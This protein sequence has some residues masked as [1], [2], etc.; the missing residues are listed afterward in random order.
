VGDNDDRGAGRVQLPQ[1]R[2]DLGAGGRVE[3][4][5][6]LVGQHQGR[7][8]GHG[9]G[10]GDPLPLATGQLV[11]PVVEPVPKPDPVE[12]GGRQVAPDPAGDA[13][14]EQAV[15]HVVQR[16]HPTGQVE[17]LE[18]E[19]DRAGAQRGQRAVAE[20]GD[21]VRRDQH[22]S[23]RR[24][25]QRPDEVEQR[26][27]SGPGRADDRDEFPGSHPQIHVA[28]RGDPTQVPPA[29]RAQVHQRGH[30]RPLAPRGDAFEV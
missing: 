13:R 29:D 30:R 7:I 6:G 20:P 3:V 14:V 12:G 15:G 26:R 9:P 18:D 24:L 8:A 1:Q 2:D 22:G 4:A 27:L 25:V 16:A 28:Q 23:A 10:D 21:V 5:R 11:R 19:A 17:L